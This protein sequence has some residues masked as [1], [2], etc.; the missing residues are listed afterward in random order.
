[1]FLIS[2]LFY[3][4]CVEIT[5]LHHSGEREGRQRA[6]SYYFIWPAVPAAAAAAAAAAVDED[7]DEE[8]EDEGCCMV[9]RPCMVSP[10]R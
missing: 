10:L 4:V 5:I 6:S 3:E 9:E 7:I 1:M 2:S 8:D